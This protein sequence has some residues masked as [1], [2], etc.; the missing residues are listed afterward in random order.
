MIITNSSIKDISEIFKLYDLATDYQRNKFP[1]NEWP[2]FDLEFI[3]TEIAEDRQFKIMLNGQVACIWAI[4]Y[5]DAE[6]WEEKE[7]DDAIYLHRIATNPECRG[8]NFVQVIADWAQKFAK[9]KDRKYVR[10]D[11][12]G[13]NEVLIEYYKNCGFD[14]LGMKKLKNSSGLQ[15]HYQNADVCYF[16]REV[17]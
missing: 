12:C 7:N 14:F 4:T 11:T 17:E 9:D 2:K 10:M 1:E 8:N 5:N 16:E 6:I 3:K 15:K 13:N